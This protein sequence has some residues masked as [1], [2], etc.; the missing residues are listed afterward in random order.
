MKKISLKPPKVS[1]GCQIDAAL[2][3]RM[4]RVIAELNAGLPANN[5]WNKNSFLSRMIEYYV[6]DMEKEYRFDTLKN[7][8]AL[9]SMG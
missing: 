9:K 6:A 4:D 3:V 5:R 1:V 8:N 2:L 7:E